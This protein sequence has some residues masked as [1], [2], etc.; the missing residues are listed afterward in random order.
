MKHNSFEEV[1]GQ[2]QISIFQRHLE[3]SVSFLLVFLVSVYGN[4]ISPVAHIVFMTLS[5]HRLVIPCVR[6]Y[7]QL[8]L[9]YIQKM[10]A[11]CHVF[12]YHTGSS[13]R[14]IKIAS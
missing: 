11:A 9:K 7:C 12:H 1:R 6:K 4:Y 8:Y 13:L 14:L 10:T 2:R 5:L 3:K